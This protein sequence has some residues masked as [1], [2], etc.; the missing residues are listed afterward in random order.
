MKRRSITKKELIEHIENTFP[1]EGLSIALSNKFNFYT[2]LNIVFF[3]SILSSTFTLLITDL[4]FNVPS[5]FIELL[6]VGTFLFIPATIP[7][8]IVKFFEFRYK[9]QY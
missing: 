6:K 4:L 8:L 7:S 1:D 2:W 9:Y 5:N 3:S